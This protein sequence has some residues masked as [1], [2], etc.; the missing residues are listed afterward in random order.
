MSDVE[1]SPLMRDYPR[2][3]RIDGEGVSF[4]AE[5]QLSMAKLQICADDPDQWLQN[6][7]GL[8]PPPVMREIPSGLAS[9]AWLSPGEWLVTGPEEDVEAIRARCAQAAGTLGLM[10]NITHARVSFE[11]CGGAARAVIASHCPL[12]LGEEAMPVGAA[13]RSLFS[14]TGFFISRRADRDGVPCFR[15]IFDQTMAAYAERMLRVT[16]S[17]AIL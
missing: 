12:D 5:P 17:G 6:V 15:L 10:V 13:T 7:L 4:I 1:Q 14:D 2:D 8:T 9:I 11:L 16:I 3:V